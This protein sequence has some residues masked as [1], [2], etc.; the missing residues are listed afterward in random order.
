V[1]RA[2]VSKDRSIPSPLRP[3]QLSP[4][5]EGRKL[6]RHVDAFGPGYRGA[7]STSSLGRKAESKPARRRHREDFDASPNLAVQRNPSARSYG[8]ETEPQ[9]KLNRAGK[10]SL[11][12]HLPETRRGLVGVRLCELSV[13]PDV[14]DLRAKLGFDLLRDIEVLVDREVPII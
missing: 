11:V 6:R 1:P 13:V 7:D 12:S 10:V 3:F 5:C 14:E 8:L 9:R 2:G 4:V